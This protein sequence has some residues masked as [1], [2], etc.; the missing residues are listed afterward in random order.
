MASDLMR[1]TLGFIGDRFAVRQP[2]ET[3]RAARL[4]PAQDPRTVVGHVAEARPRGPIQRLRRPSHEGL[5]PSQPELVE[6][7]IH[8]DIA[9][10][11]GRLT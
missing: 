1:A 7:G 2:D 6:R 10:D 4:F 11:G 9:L 3:E 5:Y 8:E